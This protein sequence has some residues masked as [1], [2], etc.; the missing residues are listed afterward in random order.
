MSYAPGQLESGGRGG[1]PIVGE[2]SENAMRLWN[3]RVLRPAVAKVTTGRICDATVKL[4][5]HSHASACHYVSTLTQPEILR[6]LS[7]GPQVHHQHYAAII[8]GIRGRTYDSLD[9]LIQV[10]RVTARTGSGGRHV[11]TSGES[12]PS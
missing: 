6:R 11:V 8:D 7:H 12:A 3:R 2:M 9:A 10:A 1:D 5:R 4:L